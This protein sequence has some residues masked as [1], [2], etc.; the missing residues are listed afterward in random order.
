MLTLIAP[1]ATQAATETTVDT[2]PAPASG[3]ISGLPVC[4]TE[5]C[6]LTNGGDC[7]TDQAE[8]DKCPEC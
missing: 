5:G 2:T 6:P 7:P 8:I 3:G 1:A 4:I